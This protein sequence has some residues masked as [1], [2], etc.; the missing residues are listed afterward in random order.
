LLAQFYDAAGRNNPSR[1]GIG[2]NGR[3]WP[4]QRSGAGDAIAPEL[5]PIADDSPHLAPAGRPALAVLPDD[6]HFGAVALHTGTLAPRAQLARSPQHAGAHVVERGGLRT[7]EEA[8][9]FYT[10]RVADDAAGTDEACPPRVGAVANDGARPDPRG[11]H[12][13][14]SR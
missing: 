3:M 8:A 13:H 12:D 10:R 14:G 7:V 2:I 9:S 1:H 6:H 4:D 5:S 11:A